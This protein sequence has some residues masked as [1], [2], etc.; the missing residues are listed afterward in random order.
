S[1]I[2][3]DLAEQYKGQINVYK[4]NTDREKELSAAFGI[5]S[6]PAFLFC[7]LNGTPQMSAGIAQTAEETQA[8]FKKIIDEFLLKK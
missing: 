8:I 3:E 5:Q 1:P 7:P 4:V 6:I 2:L